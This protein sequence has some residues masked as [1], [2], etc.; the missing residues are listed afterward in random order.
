MSRTKGENVWKEVRHRCRLSDEEVHM[1]RELG[2][3]PRAL[4]ANEASRK[5]EAWKKPVGEWIR[6]LYGRSHRT[7]KTAGLVPRP[8]ETL[9][10][11]QGKKTSPSVIER[12]AAR[13]A[14]GNGGEYRS[15][16]EAIDGKEEYFARIDPTRPSP[17]KE[18]N[19]LVAYC[20][21]N[22][23]PLEDFH[24]AG[25]PIGDDE[26]RTFMIASCRLVEAWLKVR[27]TTLR[28][29][30]ERWWGWVNSYH[31]LYC[32]RWET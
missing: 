22:E 1:A 16:L 13:L 32:S 24:A 28:E 2:M 18:A 21:R 7:P 31:R 19:A 6:E 11:P 29:M 25:C 20:I 30:P 12:W 23:G 17:R 14:H 10:S 27:E 4:L 8:F 5:S 9:P 3:T 26:M 15:L